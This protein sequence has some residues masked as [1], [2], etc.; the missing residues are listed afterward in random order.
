M[1]TNAILLGLLFTYLQRFV[2]MRRLQVSILYRLDIFKSQSLGY[3]TSVYA[4]SGQVRSLYSYAMN[5][6]DKVIFV[7][8]GSSGIGAAIAVKFA[9]HG[10]KVAIVG[11]NETKLK[12][13]SVECERSGSKP[14][15]IIADV[16]RDGDADKAISATITHFGKIDV[17]VNNAGITGYSSIVTND[18]MVLF[19]RIMSVNLR[20]AV[21]ITHLTVP[22][23][24]ETKGNI[25]NVSSIAS[26]CALS[27]GHYAYCTSKA[28][29]DHFSRCIA[30]ELAPK[31]VRVN[32]VNPGPVKTD[33][34]ENMRTLNAYSDDVWEKLKTIM[35]LKRIGNSEEIADLVIFVASDN[36]GSVTGSS[37]FSDNGS[38]VRGAFE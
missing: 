5:F 14:L 15:I 1:F 22:Y 13:V 12:N 19:D 33:F 36:A 21:Y 37:F 2:I 18:T 24:I 32:T 9:A 20:A 35:P 23:L 27:K 7:T 29:L 10:A 38:L 30:L 25:I 3:K 28:A 26:T 31:G 6:N 16:A 17:L 11:R 34:V 4:L 8:G